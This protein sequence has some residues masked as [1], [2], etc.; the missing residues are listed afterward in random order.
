MLMAHVQ[1][2][3]SYF[4]CNNFSTKYG[5]PI[6]DEKHAHTVGRTMK[7]NVTN[8]STSN[9][10]AGSMIVCVSNVYLILYVGKVP[11]KLVHLLSSYFVVANCASR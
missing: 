7:R 8:C 3:K 6:M 11:I 2:V 10:Q 4:Q 9:L 1:Y 5:F